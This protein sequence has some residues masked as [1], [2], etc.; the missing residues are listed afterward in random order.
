MARSSRVATS[1]V[2]ISRVAHQQV[3]A[4]ARRK[5]C[6][7]VRELPLASQAARMVRHGQPAE[8]RAGVKCIVEA[9]RATEIERGHAGLDC[10]LAPAA[11]TFILPPRQSAL[12]T[13][14]EEG[15]TSVGEPQNRQGF[16]EQTLGARTSVGLMTTQFRW[17]V[18][19]LTKRHREI[20]VSTK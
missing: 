15:N 3:P 19:E 13:R 4:R 12:L 17:V 1:L 18:G 16:G 10:D 6:V 9:L 2:V 11:P 7:R 20:S 8:S 5:V 14:P